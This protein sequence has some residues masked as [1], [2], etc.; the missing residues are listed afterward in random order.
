[1][2]TWLIPLSCLGI[3]SLG[4]QAQD[5]PPAPPGGS[6]PN[7]AMREACKADFDKLCPG[8][9][10]GGGRIMACLHEHKDEL[11]QPCHDAI[12]AARAAHHPPAGA[13]S[14]QPP[15]SKPPQ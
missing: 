2:R 13:P 11:S 7:A 15:P 5:A 3:F 8:V 9:K 6:G 14:D 10:P 4:V 1:M 12:A